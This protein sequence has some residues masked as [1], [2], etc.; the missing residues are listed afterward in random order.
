MIDWASGYSSKWRIMRVDPHSW[1]DT[2]EL[3]GVTG[4]RIDRDCTDE[5]PLLEAAS[6]DCDIMVNTEFEEG[7]Y[8]IELLA[9]QNGYFER[10]P[11]STLLLQSGS[12]SVDRGYKQVSIDGYSVLQ[13]AADRY[14]TAGTYAP[15]DMN[16]V[17]FVR[18]LLEN[19]TPAPVV[20]E[21]SF[22]LNDHYVF[23][24]GTSYI[25][26]IWTILDAGD[27]V[28][29]I[30]GS[31]RIHILPKPQESA[32]ELS[33]ETE[34]ML[35]PSMDYE[36][37]LSSVPNRYITYYGNEIVAEVND[38]EDSLTSTIARQ[39]YIDYIDDDPI[40]VN[41]ESLQTYARRMLVE[42]STVMKKY[43]YTREYNP[44]IL[45]FS[46]VKCSVNDRELMGDFRILGQTLT[47]LNG[48]TVTEKVGLEIMEYTA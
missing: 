35:L 5:Y 42:M 33:L 28:M 25:E 17:D 40:L 38:Q 46:M 48:V 7:W 27:F 12:G 10:Y 3:S 34:R 22:T 41:G 2:E 24:L 39:R 21:G 20:T 47:C 15:K 44:D 19:C 32:F 26:A 6:L 11:I 14:L 37:D 45:P 9:E 1:G 4:V 8:R 29:Q 43:S 36:F 16:A 30:D 18:R 23:P 31:G 13:P